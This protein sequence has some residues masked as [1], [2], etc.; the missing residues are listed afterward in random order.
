MATAGA[1]IQL[2][3]ACRVRQ[4]GFGLLFY[5]SRGPRLLFAATGNLLP[6]D[7]YS[8]QRRRDEF[9][10]EVTA[11]QQQ[12]LQKFV[13]QLLEKGFLREQ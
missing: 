13:N 2:H 8:V 5:D 12:S 9:P 7:F 10:A 11:A 4:E 1:G 6:P 3:P